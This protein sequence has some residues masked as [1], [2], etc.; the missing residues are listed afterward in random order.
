MTWSRIFGIVAAIGG[1]L[2]AITSLVGQLDKSWGV[3][4]AIAAVF[5]TAT[6]ERIQGGKSK[7]DD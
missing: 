1:G 2:A 3:G 7:I 4:I 6:T 5:I